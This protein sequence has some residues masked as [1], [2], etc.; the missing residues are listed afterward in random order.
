MKFKTFRGLVIAGVI[1]VGGGGLYL[2]TRGSKKKPRPAP[3]VSQSPQPSATAQPTA[4]PSPSSDPGAGPGEPL[5][6]MDEAILNRVA[7]GI[8]GDK[9]K[10]AVPKQPWKVNLYKDAGQPAVNRLK[11]DLDSD[12]KWDEKW[13]FETPGEREGGVRADRMAD[14]RDRAR[15]DVRHEPR[16]ADQGGEPAAQPA[17]GS[18][19]RHRLE[20]LL[21]LR[22][23]P[24]AARSWRSRR[25]TSEASC[26]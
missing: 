4:T 25:I 24:Y 21:R 17:F 12:D 20:P 6:F 8:S 14:D 2:A 15:V 19:F 7:Q 18:I 16:L 1:V 22:I 3:V 11:V 13:T 26:R 23:D 9:A 10:D 5:R